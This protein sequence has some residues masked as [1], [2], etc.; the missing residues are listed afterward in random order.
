MRSFLLRWVED[1]PIEVIQIVEGY[2]LGQ[3]I[4]L[5]RH[6]LTVQSLN[7]R[8]YYNPPQQD[9]P[10]DAGLLRPSIAHH[11]LKIRVQIHRRDQNVSGLVAR[12]LQCRHSSLRYD[13]TEGEEAA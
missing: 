13:A 3:E 1:R 9:G 12:R 11:T 2:G 8:I 4:G 5:V 6:V 10:C 7:N